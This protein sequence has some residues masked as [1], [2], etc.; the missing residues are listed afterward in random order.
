VIKE[1]AKATVFLA[2]GQ[3]ALTVAGIAT[4]KVIAIRLGPYGVG[5]TGQLNWLRLL[6]ET[7]AELGIGNAVVV[8]VAECVAQNNRSALQSLFST[9]LVVAGGFASLVTLVGILA[10]PRIAFA[11]LSDRSLAYLVVILS[12]VIPFSTLSRVLSGSLQGLLEVRRLMISNIVVAGG[13]IAALLLV[14]LWGLWGFAISMILVAVMQMLLLARLLTKALDA[15]AKTIR[16][17][18]RVEI[19]L[20]LRLLQLSAALLVTQGILALESVVVNAVVIRHLG[21]DQAGLYQAGLG[22][23]YKLL[24]ILLT[25]NSM[26]VLP[27]ISGAGGDLRAIVQFKNDSLRVLFLFWLP[28]ACLVMIFRN[29]IVVSLYH[30]GFLLAA[31]LYGLQLLGDLGVILSRPL[32]IGMFSMRHFRAYIGSMAFQSVFR[33]LSLYV[34]MSYLGLHATVVSYAIATWVTAVISYGYTRKAFGFMFDKRSRTLLVKSLVVFIVT[35]ALV[36]STNSVFT[37]VASTILLIAWCLTALPPQEMAA[38]Y[39]LGR[40]Q[41]GV[42][43]KKLGWRHEG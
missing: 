30:Q 27:K 20:G 21:A 1:Q 16:P 35:G 31:Q 28:L 29:V 17:K 25:A 10:S 8:L 43:R 13:T 7:I 32:R 34:L 6:M 15:S 36:Y 3:V 9:S 40:K 33:T 5:V 19:A 37:Y 26:Y 38:L 24:G 12:L 11:S 18:L 23:P 42:G 4:T 14:W 2:I 41:L 22:V 39:A